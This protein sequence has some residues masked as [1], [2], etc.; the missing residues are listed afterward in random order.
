MK[1][2]CITM[3]HLFS[4]P[5]VC[6]CV[7]ARTLSHF[8]CVGVFATLWTLAHQVLLSIG[9]LQTRILEWVICPPPGDPPNPGIKPSV[10]IAGRFFTI[11][12]TREALPCYAAAAAAK[13]LQSCP[14]LQP[15]RRQPSRLLHPW[16]YYC[17]NATQFIFPIC[18]LWNLPSNDSMNVFVLVFVCMWV[19]VHIN[20]ENMH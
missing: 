3:V 20:V 16:L 2:I 4:L 13:S 11:W 7:C 8:S 6:V 19:N 10:R 17:V 1:S 14:T 18:Y 12:A 5:C 15:H 9:I